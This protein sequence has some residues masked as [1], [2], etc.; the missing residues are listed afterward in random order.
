MLL[1]EDFTIILERYKNSNILC[2]R[3]LEAYPFRM[4]EFELSFQILMERIEKHSIKKIIANC[5]KTMIHLPDEEYRSVISLLQSGL[6]HSKIE[7]IAHI[8]VDRSERDL[9]CITYFE[10]ILNDMQLKIQFRN[11]DDRKSALLW[12]RN[13]EA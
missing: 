9:Q 2:V 5:S 8:Y 12:L 6:A 1:Y 3:W 10:E 11:F 13:S 4:S 7:K